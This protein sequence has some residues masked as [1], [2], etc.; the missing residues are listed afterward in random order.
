M[1]ENGL[2][3]RRLALT[4]TILFNAGDGNYWAAPR[5]AISGDGCLVVIGLEF[6]P[7]RQAACD[8]DRDRLRSSPMIAPNNCPPDDRLAAGGTCGIG[9]ANPA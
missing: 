5:A 8:A 1:R 9:K 7:D 2:E 6:R 3:I 4:R